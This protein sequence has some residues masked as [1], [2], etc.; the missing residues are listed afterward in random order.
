MSTHTPGPWCWRD[1]SATYAGT[2]GD[3]YGH[4]ICDMA[5]SYS[6]LPMAELQANARLIA[7]GP[8]LLRELRLLNLDQNG[9]QK[10]NTPAW[11][12]I[13]KATGESA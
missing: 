5:C 10:R 9:E 11:R 7:A 12:V 6:S 1:H 3:T 8:E 4:A 2:I 13:A